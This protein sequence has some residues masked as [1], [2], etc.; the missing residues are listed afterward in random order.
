MLHKCPICNF[1]GLYQAPY[2]IQGVGSDEICPCCGFQ[3][4]YDDYPDK[5]MAQ[6]EWRKKWAEGGFQWF[7]KT[8]ITVEGWD[9]YKQLYE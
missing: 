6:L 1:K 5:K 2:N 7:S 9:G 3:Y 4:G 8:R